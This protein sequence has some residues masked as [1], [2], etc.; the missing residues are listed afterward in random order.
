MRNEKAVL[1]QVSS[2]AANNENVRAAILTSSR[3]DPKRTLDF[4]SDYDIELYVLD[5]KA[6]E[7]DDW[8]IVFGQIMVRWPLL[9]RFTSKEG[10]L[11][12]LVLFKDGIRIDFQILDKKQIEP[13]T[14]ENGF[15]VLIDKDGL[16]SNLN[17]PTYTKYSIQKPTE[18]YFTERV[19]AFWW[20]AA[21]VPKH[22]WRDELPFA[23]YMMG[24]S[25]RDKSLRIIIEWTIGLQNN[26]TVETGLG[27]RW[28]KRYLDETTWSEYEST[29]ATADI[30]DQWRAFINAVDLFTRLAR[31]VAES[32]EYVYPEMLEGE[33]RDY[34]ERMMCTEQVHPPIKK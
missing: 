17:P 20:D 12:R 32:L 4:L 33:R 22:L 6:F 31:H 19:N 11:T 5:L 27:G 13:D 34:F 1:N 10:G 25:V 30:E 26:W 28:F 9:P 29:F 3:V 2:W 24:Q 15:R 14:Y 8:L 16:T 7:N 21:Y 23:A 18:A